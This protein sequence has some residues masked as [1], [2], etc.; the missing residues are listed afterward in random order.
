MFIGTV[1]AAQLLN[2][3]PRRVRT[4][5]SQGRIEGAYKLGRA[6]LIPLRDGR[7]SLIEGKRGPK[8]R[9]SKLVRKPR[10]ENLAV[11]KVLRDGIAKN[12]KKQKV[13]E[14]VISIKRE[15]NHAVHVHEILLNGPSRLCYSLTPRKDK[16]GATV[17]L[18][19][20]FGAELFRLN[21][22]T[23]ERESIGF[24]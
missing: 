21:N 10:Q 2:I 13:E 7:P 15:H 6:W 14:A 20:Y 4:L 5:L 8:S 9:W 11:V 22:L 1:Q 24:V 12:F 3:S 17:W 23:K 19:T 16:G 18:E